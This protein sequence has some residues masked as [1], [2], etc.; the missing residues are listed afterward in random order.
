[1]SSRADD[2]TSTSRQFLG[3]MRDLRDT[4][5]ENWPSSQATVAIVVFVAV[6]CA[7]V[8]G[9]LRDGQTAA[10]VYAPRHAGGIPQGRLPV[11]QP[12]ETRARLRRAGSASAHSYRRGPDARTMMSANPTCGFLDA[13]LGT[14]VVAIK[15]TP[16]PRLACGLLAPLSGGEHARAK[17]W[18]RS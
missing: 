10:L 3:A 17:T 6:L 18:V 12:R 8:Y 2:V 13:P 4:L 1:M 15:S 9:L 16:T 14:P 5:Y 7:F 11:Q